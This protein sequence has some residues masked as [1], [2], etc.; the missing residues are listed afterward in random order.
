MIYCQDYFP[1][2][3]SQTFPQISLKILSVNFDFI[4]VQKSSETGV[5]WGDFG[6]LAVEVKLGDH[7]LIGLILWM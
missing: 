6:K 7:V 2:E 3:G 5:E 4:C 1:R